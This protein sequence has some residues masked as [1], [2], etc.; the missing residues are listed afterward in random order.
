MIKKR[1]TYQHGNLPAALAEAVIELVGERGVRGFSLAEAAR[2][3]GVSNSAPYRHFADRDAL[4]VAVATQAYVEFGALIAAA[5]RKH[6][7]P[8]P[9]LQ[10]MVRAYV[11]YATSD[12]ARF[13]ILF[14][15]GL[16]KRLYPALERAGDAALGTLVETVAELVPGPPE[17]IA[18]AALAFRACAHGFAMLT[19]DGSLAHEGLAPA[20]VVDAAVSAVLRLAD[21]FAGRPAPAHWNEGRS[22]TR[23]E[24]E[25]F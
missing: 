7:G 13:E 20:S 25:A 6:R 2:R 12:R 3:S 15:S 4:L 8:R 22:T 10:A 21:S 14:N 18:D 24:R 5:K 17:R 16:D 19:I 9:Q 11:S 1:T 23:G